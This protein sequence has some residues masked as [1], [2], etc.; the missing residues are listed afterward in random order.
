MIVSSVLLGDLKR[1]LGL[2]EADLR[3]QSEDL[4]V[5]WAAELRAEHA[6]A[7]QR[8]R[9]ART[10]SEWR[11][12]EVAQAAVAWIIATTFVRFCED[13]HLLDGAA[14]SAIWIAGPG[15]RLGRAVEN[16]TA[17]YAEHPDHNDR[18][19][20]HVA[21]GVLAGLPPGR[22]LVDPDHNSVWRAPISGQ[23]AKE[24]VAFWRRRDDSGALV[25]DFTDPSL[26][27][28]FLGDLYQDLSEYAKKTYALLQTPVFVE[29]FI[30][31]QT[32]TPALAE[33]G[34]DGL[35]LIDPTCGSGH[36]LLGAF[37]R[38]N[39]AWQS[40]APNLDPRTRV[41]RALDSIHGVDLNP[42]AVAIARFRL[43]VAA[44]KE[45]GERTLTD[46]P[47]F[48]YHLAIGD[49]LLGAQGTQQALNLSGEDDGLFEYAAEDLRYYHGILTT[50]RYHVVV[51]NPPYITPKDKAANAAYRLAYPEVCHRQYALSVPFMDLF[52]RLAIRGDGATPAGYVGQ[53]TANSF[54]KREF[55][56]KV[57]ENLLSGRNLANPVDL[58][59][60]ID[61]SGAYIPGHGTPTVI[62]VGRRRRPTGDSIRAALGV[63]GEPGQPQHPAKGLVWT[64]I[65]EHLEA[66]YNGTYTTITDLDR[67]VLAKHPWSLSGGG[68]GAV[69]E[70]L[71]EQAVERLG[72]VVTRIGFMAM[73]H[74]DE[75]FTYPAEM[76]SRRRLPVDLFPELVPGEAVRDFQV[77]PESVTW[78]PYDDGELVV[79]DPGSSEHRLL[80]PFRSD[81]AARATFG[82]G[83]YRS[84]GRVWYEWHQVPKD[85]DASHWSLTF[86]FVSTI[87][88]FVLDRGGKVFK[89][90]APVIKLP[91]GASESDHLALL[92]ILNS[93][94]ACFWL[95]QVS[96]SR[97]EG[98]GA[99]VDAGYAAMGSEAWKDTYEFT[100][101]KLQ[102]FP[103]AD[104]LPE[105][106]GFRLDAL[107][108]DLKAATPAE[109]T[110]R[111]VGDVTEAQGADGSVE[112]RVS[113]AGAWRAWGATEERPG[114][115]GDTLAS[116]LG[117][118][119]QAWN[120]TRKRMIFEQEELDW[121]TYYLY[122]L[123]DND[124][125]LPYE[126]PTGTLNLGERAFEIALARKI[127][128]GEEESAWFERHGS[129][130]ITELPSRWPDD[131]RALVQRRLDLIESDPFIN[132]LER[133]EYK[134]RWATTPWETQQSDALRTLILDRLEAP[135]LWRDPQGAVVRSVAQLA[136]A[137]RND[138]V[139]REAFQILHG[140]PDVDLTPALTTLLA[141]EAVPF[142]AAYR[143]KDTGVTKY[144]EWQHV[145]DL[146]RRED[147]GETVTIPVPPRY[148]QADFRRPSYWKAR[149]KLDVPKERFIA[150]PG[151][152]RAGDTTP[153][154]G[155]AG[156]DHADQALA[157]A[158]LTTDQVGLGADEDAVTPL[159]AGL[160]ELEPWLHQWHDAPDPGRGGSVPAAAITGMIEQMLG[161]FGL[162]R[163]DLTRWAPPA[164][165]RGRRP[166]G[167]APSRATP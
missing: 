15:E 106:R 8:G 80:W 143:Y 6:R 128:A 142:L 126:H 66:P 14:P 39:E 160:Q 71:A 35:K 146:Q 144:R 164:P 46:A 133:P 12:G 93:S 157:L 34:L 102:D 56:T 139:I 163:D 117:H 77:S 37:D 75:Q 58:T 51:G 135:D 105:E 166:G 54:M 145:W 40:H 155:W 7:M 74:A 118:A 148:A 36:F 11:D 94:L 119:R 167:R 50:G 53:I 65:L 86:A 10:W 92:G 110:R 137:V 41:Q 48:D 3:G 149:G 114:G 116:T 89:Q 136:D 112:A 140:R 104:E 22:A 23:A 17:Y 28:R 62:L 98:G 31:D 49:S 151:V 91:A 132:L 59:K 5:P 158:R 83:T 95:K 127:A 38:L 99:R 4:E 85:N 129:S 152:A 141:D 27:A 100:G 130:P 138:E 87:N 165:T 108:L 2:L 123:T 154:L 115:A 120:K 68:A 156:W 55:G 72:E 73:S 78:F 79:P 19:W 121:E 24:L 107:A 64:E 43:T 9:T 42:F 29:E 88:H 33:F 1:Q 26:D 134:R 32:L 20:L 153:V 109:V 70:H 16:Q 162:T 103:L 60:V 21:F 13:N 122:S 76:V 81:L 82:G 57:I 101:T 18:D 61:T 45:S 150:Y 161:R 131:Y 67:T 159:L 84:T 69:M 124:L 47:A 111:L 97:G 44:L 147:A 125:S 96:Q 90:T 63:R 30:L 113:P 52:F 25:H